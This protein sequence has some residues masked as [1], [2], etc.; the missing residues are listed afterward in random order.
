MNGRS[1]PHPLSHAYIV[2][3]GGEDSRREYVRRLTA[4]FLCEGECP[5]CGVCRHCIKVERD[6]HPDVYRLTPP[7]GRQEI[8]AALARDLRA[9]V[10]VRPNEGAR[11][12]Y[13]ID[14]ADAMNSTAQNALLKVIEDGPEYAAFL[15]L[16]AQPGQLLETVRSRCETL[17]L[18][19]EEEKG[20]PEL[21]RQGEEL[22][23]L[24]LEG[25]EWELAQ[26]FTALE[27]ERRKSAQTLELLAAAETAAAARLST[28]RRAASALRLLKTCRENEVYNVGTGHIL[29]WLCAKMAVERAGIQQK[30]R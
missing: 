10:Y 8:T 5:P 20:D 23:R 9:D 11:K 4:A 18:P 15:L 6:I 3:G 19:P 13:I 2:A 29:G 22:A 21:A 1:I 24:L 26:S 16:A 12:V 28:N 7:E 17:L 25:S 27:V 30:N 14:P